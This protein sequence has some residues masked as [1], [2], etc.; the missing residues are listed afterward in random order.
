M[1]ALEFWYEFGS[2]YSYPAAMRL[3]SLAEE[4]GVGLRWRP[5]L[6]GPIFK[7]YGWNDSPFNI[8]EAKGRYMWR[9]LTRICEGEGLPLKLPPVHFPQ[10]GLKAARLALVGEGEGWTPPFTRAVFMANYAEQ[11][12]ISDDET[13]RAI[14]AKLGV[15]AEAALAEANALPIKDR[16]KQQTAEA[17]RR[18]MFG[19]PSFT[20]GDELFWGNDRLE[21]ALEWA[22]AYDATS[23]RRA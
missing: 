17:A 14:L 10:N 1:V 19:A 21:A 5:F 20:I 16:L 3:E 23:P 6:L 12:D 2:T 22:T 9:D 18:G 11:R 8:Y 13:L 7:E 4:S 15:D